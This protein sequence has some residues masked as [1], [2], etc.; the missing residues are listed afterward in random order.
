MRARVQRED[1]IE[2]GLEFGQ[3]TWCTIAWYK[4]CTQEMCDFIINPRKR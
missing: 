2:S 4:L 1:Y 3:N